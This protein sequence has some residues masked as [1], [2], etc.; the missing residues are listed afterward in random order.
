MARKPSGNIQPLFGPDAVAPR[1]AAAVQDSNSQSKE[2][3]PP[4]GEET[5]STS[6]VPSVPDGAGGDSARPN[7][8]VTELSPQGKTVAAD[9]SARL[10]PQAETAYA[11]YILP[12]LPKAEARPAYAAYAGF[13]VCVLLPLLVATLYYTTFASDQYL[14]EFRFTVKD[15]TANSTQVPGSIMALVGGS[16]GGT[17]SSDD[18]Y[19]VTDFLTS[20]EAVEELEKQIKVTDLY[21]KPTIDWWSRFNPSQPMEKFIPY[22]QQMVTARYDQV[23]GLAVAQVKAFTP[24]DTLLIANTLVALSEELVNKIANRTQSDIMRFSEKEVERAENR[25][26]AIS[27]RLM[28]YRNR[29]GVIDPTVSVAA[30]N[31]TL[32][33]TL[34]ASLVQFET[35]LGALI[36]QKVSPNSAVVETIKNQIKSTKEQLQKTE[37]TVGT[38][39]DGSSLSTVMAEYEQLD[40]ERQFAMGMLTSARTSLDQARAR[41]TAQNLYITP[42][43]RPHLPRSAIYPKRVLSI[44]TVGMLAFAAWVVGMLILRSIRE[45]FA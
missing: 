14:A 9:E 2:Q 21:A 18:N 36:Q 37:A 32:I 23:T 13:A 28:E 27:A 40:L 30:S 1:D 31:A 45:R 7:S 35:Q 16:V 39:R 43:V 11:Q 5:S 44:A 34:R 3:R 20:Q 10:S 25:L 19:L 24:E 26:K 8:G 12:P 22:W 4:S 29:T 42:Y 33:M 15:A 41:A 17:S 6:M 38:N